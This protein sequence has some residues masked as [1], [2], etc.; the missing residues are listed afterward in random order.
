MCF[1]LPTEPVV[2]KKR[3]PTEI[4]KPKWPETE[5]RT[6][7]H[8]NDADILVEPFERDDS[9]EKELEIPP[10]ERGNIGKNFL[11][12]IFSEAL[13]V[14]RKNYIIIVPYFVPGTLGLI[15][16]LGRAILLPSG[17]LQY[18]FIILDILCWI[19]F[20]VAD[21]FAI[22]ITY[23]ALR[24]KKVTLCEAWGEIGLKKIIVLL[25]VDLVL[26]VISMGAEK[27]IFLGLCISSIIG[28]L[29]VSLFIF[30]Y[31]GIVIDNLNPIATF[32]NSYKIVK[33]EFFIVLIMALLF[34]FLV[35]VINISS[36]NEI[37][38]VPAEL[39]SI[40]ALTIL[41]VERK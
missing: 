10:S 40:V 35:H 14:V 31:Q 24:K 32:Y 25:I 37:L 6:E 15:G 3:V 29:L 5:K 7:I 26:M 12:H 36:L 22:N 38:S 2:A 27:L 34:L 11:E 16:P 28:E 13:N 41:Y 39:Y 21:A 23:N 19:F 9:Y 18:L 8:K 33:K 17:R 30:V 1:G 20:I 4:R